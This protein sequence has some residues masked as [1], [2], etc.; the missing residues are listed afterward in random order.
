[1]RILDWTTLDE[2]ARDAVLERPGVRDATVLRAA[3]QRT[4]EQVRADGDSTLRALTRR[5]DGCELARFE[6][7]EDEFAAAQNAVSPALHAAIEA[8]AARIEAFHRAGMPQAFAL[9]TAPGVRCERVLRPIARVGLYVPAGSAPLPSTALMLG[10]PARLAGCP[11]IVLCTP[12]RNDGRVDETVLVAARR[13]GITR[14]YKLGGAQA[15]AAM[16]YGTESIPRCDKVFGP[17]NAHVTEAKQQVAMDPQGAAVDLP[18]GP[19][20]VLVVADAG[21]DAAFVA[22]DLLSQAE[23]GPDSQ[24]LLLSDS[25]ALLA[26]VAQQIAVQAALLPRREILD[27]ALA[28]ARLVR[29]ADITQAVEISNR[30]APEHLILA[31]R[32][33]R[34][35]L[36]AVA[37]AGS[38]FLGDFAPEALGDYCSGTNHVLP[39]C[40]AARAFSG[41]SVASFLKQ[42]TVQEVTPAGLAAIGPDA[43]ELARAERLAAHERAVTL[44]LAR[45]EPSP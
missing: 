27:Q 21:A 19:S 41:V 37:S 9:E 17:G 11:D 13:C 35:W 29:C 5:Y 23:H 38:V 25:D 36:D 10:I 3:V 33:P 30:Y 31:V 2:A 40:G 15:I 43:A 6:V 1:M 42:I 8:S 45:Q 32:E 22:A 18:A 34:R 44:R 16:A 26:A 4:I 39:T 7:D 12:P 24:V 14:V 28:H 20:E